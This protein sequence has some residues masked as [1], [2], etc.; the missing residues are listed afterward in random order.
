MNEPNYEFVKGTGWVP[1]FERKLL[2]FDHEGK[3]YWVVD[4]PPQP[5]EFFM[6]YDFTN[7]DWYVDGLLDLSKPAQFLLEDTGPLHTFDG[8][9]GYWDAYLTLVP[10]DE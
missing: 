6:G 1:M 2:A 7:D 8:K 4:R 3:S 10:C 5:G 9:P